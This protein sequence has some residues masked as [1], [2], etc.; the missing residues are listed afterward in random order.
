VSQS[1]ARIGGGEVLVNG[2]LAV[3]PV[4]PG[5][6]LTAHGVEVGNAPV[7]ALPAQGAGQTQRSS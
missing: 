1:C 6:H 2:G 7:Q 5:G 3:V 4:L